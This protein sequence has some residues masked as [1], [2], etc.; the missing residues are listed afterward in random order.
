MH[1][2]SSSGAPQSRASGPAPR[3]QP[4]RPGDP[5]RIGPY[6]IIGRLG[7][8]GMGTVH[9]GLD[10]AGLRVAVKVIHPAQAEDAEFRARFRRE[11]QLSARVQGPCVLPLLAADP[12]ADTPW[13]ATAYAP[14]P[15]LD[16]H[17]SAEGP[18]SGGTLYAFATG[19]AHALAAI[20]QAGVVH[21]DV[22]PQ[23]IIL[24]PSGP[25]MLDFGIAHAADG[26]S[27]TRTGVMTGTP[28]WI[29]PEHYRTGT[30]GPAGD[31]FAWGA[32][33]AYAATGRLPFGS[34]APDVVAFRVMSGEPDLDGIPAELLPLI[35]R[36]LAKDPE[37]RITADE[38]AEECSLLLASQATQVLPVGT[39]M[40]PTR[41]G[42]LVA[43]EWHMP[44]LD[45]PTWHE[46]RP[47]L[48]TRKAALV[49]GAALVIGSL[50]GGTLALLDSSDPKASTR[51]QTPTGNASGG[52]AP[53][54]GGQQAP[55]GKNAP[56][57]PT[58]PTPSS[59]TANGTSASNE[60]TLTTW[61]ESRRAKGEQE[62]E[63]ERGIHHD[64]GWSMG[65]P[66]GVLPDSDV[67]TT[68][69]ASRREVYV[70]VAVHN[71]AEA[72][73]SHRI[74][75]LAK[76][77]C[78]SMRQFKGG[79]IPGERGM[80]P[81]LAYDSFVLIDSTDKANP[82][83][84]WEDDFFTNTTCAS[85]HHDRPVIEEG[86]DSWWQPNESGL[87]AAQTPSKDTGE[88]RAA[89]E[90]AKAI[91]A[92][93]QNEPLGTGPANRLG[94]DNMSV[95]FDPNSQT[96]YVWAK[97]P[98]WDQ[99]TRQA[100]GRAASAVACTEVL[101]EARARKDWRY[102]KY[103]VAILGGPGGEDFLYWSSAGSCSE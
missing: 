100:W 95:G 57:T 4:A 90:T 42:D 54:G 19:T 12:D 59:G 61:R 6:R 93:W 56:D 35:T 9:A 43:A 29:S 48:R 24:S 85:S 65:G 84:L 47:R 32:L 102:A 88:I 1:V 23:N 94:N 66:E 101:Q 62:N 52:D 97:K 26:T 33:C 39:D 53:T 2:T 76:G 89:D 60:A 44:T 31:M 80:Y 79:S 34:G 64:L 103:A 14:G 11:V 98:E 73:A 86:Q 72:L 16:Q 3:V 21:R 68:F 7:A 17:L 51:T 77:T 30:A 99:P 5:K 22:K 78:L 70:E 15:S 91:F 36:A 13:L 58:T 96:M 63:V 37:S 83:I 50:T 67:T 25:R 41:V 92:R 18:L 49:L 55:A 28:G 27:V 75:E 71:K 46:P 82:R 87:Q 38:A 74:T 20:H 40:A 45:D 69:H 81:D 8:G 10:D